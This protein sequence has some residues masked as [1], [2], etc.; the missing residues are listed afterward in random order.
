LR[1]GL[2]AIK[3]LAE[4]LNKPLAAISLLEAI[5]VAAPKASE[6]RLLAALD[7]GRGE[8]Y[9]GEYQVS[10]AGPTLISQNLVTHADLVRL[11]PDA[12]LVTP[13]SD[14]ARKAEEGGRPA[15]K[16]DPPRA[17]F[18]ARIGVGKI[19]AGEVVAADELEANYIRR[20]DAEIFSK[21]KL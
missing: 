19:M 18:I 7:A 8:A 17:D 3:G 14:L 13:D 4:V 2:A 12:T 6:G 11:A 5:A 9:V 1:V 10:T 15:V 20:S 16:I 21:P